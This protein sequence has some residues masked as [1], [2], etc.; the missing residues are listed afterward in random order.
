MR[1]LD[2]PLHIINYCT[3][4]KFWSIGVIGSRERKF[5][6]AAL[7][8]QWRHFGRCPIE[9]RL[10]L[11]RR[12]KSQIFL[13]DGFVLFCSVSSTSPQTAVFTEFVLHVLAFIGH[14][15]TAFF[16]VLC[17]SLKRISA[18]PF[19]GSLKN[20][21]SFS[22]ARKGVYDIIKHHSAR[23]VA[24]VRRLLR[25]WERFQQ[26]PVSEFREGY[27]NSW[28]I[29]SQGALFP[30]LS[31]SLRLQPYCSQSFT[32]C[33]IVIFISALV[34]FLSFWQPASAVPFVIPATT[35]SFIVEAPTS[36]RS[37]RGMSVIMMMIALVLR[38]L[39]WGHH[40]QTFLFCAGHGYRLY[41]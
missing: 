20:H 18:W 24:L 23:C 29:P 26:N 8:K 5:P 11:A 17:L 10:Q 6:V 28:S 34:A 1:H 13:I 15:S 27:I 22:F 37:A 12:S 3:I 25:I 16:H 2:E 31:R 41:C 39:H 21:T 40:I 32:F 7:A 14:R 19:G 9:P 35:N 36:S 4:S 30:R 33:S 38:S